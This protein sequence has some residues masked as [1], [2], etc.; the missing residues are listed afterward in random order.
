LEYAKDVVWTVLQNAAH[1]AGI[2]HRRRFDVSTDDNTHYDLKLGYES[3]HSFAI[4][5]VPSGAR[6]LDIGAG[7]GGVAAELH[8]KG[9]RVTVV[10]KHEPETDD[11][12]I[13]VIQQD[14][15]EGVRFD[16]KD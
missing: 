10:D 11:P 3:S 2:L 13:E 9:C 14:L 16:P 15:A 5:A 12:S 1:R 7:P 4:D 6:V 8:K